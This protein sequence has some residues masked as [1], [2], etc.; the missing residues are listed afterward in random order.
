[1]VI[2]AGIHNVE[3]IPWKI[4]TD[5]STWLVSFIP[6]DNNVVVFFI[7]DN[8]NTFVQFSPVCRQK[9]QSISAVL[10]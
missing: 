1:M 6:N 9:C 8:D 7:G 2:V 3:Q 4:C 10:T 5:Y